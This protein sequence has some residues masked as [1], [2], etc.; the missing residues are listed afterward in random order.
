MPPIHDINWPLWLSTMLPMAL[1]A[2]PGNLMVA[3]SGAQGHG[4]QGLAGFGEEIALGGLEEQHA[5][6]GL[7]QH[8]DLARNRRGRHLQ[9]LPGVGDVA[10]IGDG[11]EKPQIVP[12]HAYLP[13]P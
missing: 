1:S 2:G 9:R 12:V 4:Q 8:Q 6:Q 11:N 13:Y 7:L 5:A 10:G 3:S